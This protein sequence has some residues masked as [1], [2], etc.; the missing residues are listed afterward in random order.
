M[1]VLNGSDEVKNPTS[2]D[3]RQEVGLLGSDDTDFLTLSNESNGEFVQAVTS[4]EGDDEYLVEVK[5]GAEIHKSAKS[6]SASELESILND[7]LKGADLP[8][9]PGQW[10]KLDKKEASKGGGKAMFVTVA[11]VLLASV[12][13]VLWALYKGGAW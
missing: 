1:Y 3:I 6:F 7:F 9:D 12:L 10:Q 5:R 4:D 11:L 2:N 13:V 8:L